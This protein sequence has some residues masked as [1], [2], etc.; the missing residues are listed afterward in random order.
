MLIPNHIK[1]VRM[2]LRVGVIYLKSWKSPEG[3]LQGCLAL[4]FNCPLP[5]PDADP[6]AVAIVHRIF[7]DYAGIENDLPLPIQPPGP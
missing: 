3:S 4:I 2:D 5:L 6:E 7:A 1:Q